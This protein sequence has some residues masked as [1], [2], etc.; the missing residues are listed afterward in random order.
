[1]CHD[2]TKVTLD[3]IPV[4][5]ITQIIPEID[6]TANVTAIIPNIRLKKL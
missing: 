3:S 5:T 1:M 2:T 6:D 4:K